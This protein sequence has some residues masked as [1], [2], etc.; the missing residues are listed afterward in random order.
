MVSIKSYVFH[1]NRRGT[2]MLHLE[3]TIDSYLLKPFGES[4][5]NAGRCGGQ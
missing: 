4:V 1:W 5:T 2:S 3:E